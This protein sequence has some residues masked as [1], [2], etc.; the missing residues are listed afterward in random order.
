MLRVF[1]AFSGIGTQRMA[2][3]NIGFEH[4]VIGISEISESAIKAY[5]AIH[6]ETRNFGDISKLDTKDIP[7]HDLFTYSFP[8]TDVSLDGNLMGVSEGSGTRSSLLWEARRIIKVKKPRYLMLENVKNL[9]S[10]RFKDDFNTWL[11]WLESQGYNN[12]VKLINAKDFTNIPQNRERVFVLSIL[13][14][15][16]CGFSYPENITRTSVLKDFLDEPIDN[17]FIV[18]ESKFE[19]LIVPFESNTERHFIANTKKGYIVA[20]PYDSFVYGYPNSTTRRGRVGYGVAQTIQTE[21]MMGVV[22]EDFTI[23]KLTPLECWRL[24]GVK[25]EDYFKALNAG[26][27]KTALYELAGNA[28]VVPVLERIFQ[29]VL[30]NESARSRKSEIQ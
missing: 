14:E 12:Y 2:L 15:D 29:E 4:E 3:N 25:D 28:I 23:K 30:K 27:R 18:P 8:C 17:S 5:N 19:K 16:D 11:E 1:E 7:D 10:N 22:L 26:L 24:M 6:G 21:V 9:L 13:K 20:E